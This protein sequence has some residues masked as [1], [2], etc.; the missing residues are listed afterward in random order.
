MPKVKTTNDD[1]LALLRTKQPRRETLE[2]TL[3]EDTT[4]VIRFEALGAR[5]YDELV[6][7][8]QADKKPGA[9]FN[10]ETFAPALVAACAVEPVLTED[11]ARELLDEWSV[12]EALDLF[13][14]ALRVNT[15]RAA[16]AG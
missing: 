4:A 10:A 13:N 5:A 7:A 11:Q 12:A 1:L 6:A 8:H 16:V 15:T 9:P 2:V 14:A 3:G